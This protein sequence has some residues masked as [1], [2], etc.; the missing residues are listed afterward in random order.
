[1]WSFVWL[2]SRS[3][4]LVLSLTPAV[5]VCVE[6]MRVYFGRNG[7]KH[8]NVQHLSI[9]LLLSI[10]PQ[11]PLILYFALFQEVVFPCDEVLGCIMMTVLSF[12]II[13]SSRTLR[14]MIRNHAA[15]FYQSCRAKEIEM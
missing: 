9:F 7:N 4:T 12:E 8:E 14:K 1:M 10:F 3:H 13:M 15:A 6:V 11:F 5:W 2:F